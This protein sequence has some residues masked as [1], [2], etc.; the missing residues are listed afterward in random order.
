MI[1]VYWLN[2]IALTLPHFML[3]TFILANKLWLSVGKF[4]IKTGNALLRILHK[5]LVF[6]TIFNPVRSSLLE[7]RLSIGWK[8]VGRFIHICH[9]NSDL[10]S[11]SIMTIVIRESLIVSSFKSSCFVIFERHSTFVLLL[12]LTVGWLARLLIWLVAALFGCSRRLLTC[13]VFN[14][15]SYI[16]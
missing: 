8:V 10:W 4:T 12:T 2:S 6:S 9:F 16:F 5:V 7:F 3:T 11:Y 14:A 15:I 13:Y 1:S